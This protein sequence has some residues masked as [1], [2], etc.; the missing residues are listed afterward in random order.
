MLKFYSVLNRICFIQFSSKMFLF[1]LNLNYFIQ[2]IFKD[3][4]QFLNNYFN[5]IL[6]ISIF[7]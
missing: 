5:S 2:F 6:K 1:N 7:Q 3:L 4:I